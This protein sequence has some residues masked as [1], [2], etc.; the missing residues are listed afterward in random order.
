[1]NLLAVSGSCI[2][3]KGSQGSIMN[4]KLGSWKASE[5][6]TENYMASSVPQA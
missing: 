6:K 1:M 4:P 3:G 2:G 5:I